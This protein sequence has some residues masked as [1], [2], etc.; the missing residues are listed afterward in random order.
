[1]IIFRKIYHVVIKKQSTINIPNFSITRPLEIYQIWRFGMKINH[2][3][4][5]L[6]LS[7]CRHF[8]HSG[9]EHWE[10]RHHV[11]GLFMHKKREIETHWH[12]GTDS[13]KV[14]VICY[15][16][17]VHKYVIFSYNVDMEWF[18]YHSIP[19][20]CTIFEGVMWGTWSLVNT[21]R[22]VFVALA[23]DGHGEVGVKMFFNKLVTK[24]SKLE[25]G[26]LG[27]IRGCSTN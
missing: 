7:D 15:P 19:Y 22:K 8:G 16:N 20:V 3:A 5:R 17:F 6:F 25:I 27:R 11:V 4:T 12:S 2:L 24:K 21:S 13:T 26:S 9:L 14:F 10:S 1:M 23:S 18:S